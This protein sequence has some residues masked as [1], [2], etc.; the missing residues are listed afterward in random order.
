MLD[1]KKLKGWGYIDSQEKKKGG[2]EKESICSFTQQE[3]KF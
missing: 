2:K 1:F 3:E